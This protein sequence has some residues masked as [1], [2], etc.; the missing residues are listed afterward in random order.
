[1]YNNIDRYSRYTRWYI[2]V[3]YTGPNTGF[4]FRWRCECIKSLE[5]HKRQK[6][7][8]T[9]RSFVLCFLFSLDKCALF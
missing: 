1:M 9:N 3:I 4:E 7:L 6:I 5:H 8:Q 2:Y